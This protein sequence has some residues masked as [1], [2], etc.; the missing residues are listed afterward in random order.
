M[1]KSV[2]LDTILRSCLVSPTVAK[3]Y[4]VDP[5]GVAFGRYAGTHPKFATL[6]D[7][8][9]LSELSSKLVAHMTAMEAT[10]ARTRR[11]KIETGFVVLIIDEF[12]PDTMAP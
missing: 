1:G 7:P 8:R 10:L 11:S 2:A 4:A 12:S 6:S 9:A 3:V 5:S